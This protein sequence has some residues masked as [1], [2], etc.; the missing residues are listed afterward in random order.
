MRVGGVERD[1]EELDFLLREHVA[2]INACPEGEELIGPQRVKLKERVP[3]GVPLSDCSR[4]STRGFGFRY[5][6]QIWRLKLSTSAY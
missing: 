4:S 1:A 2:L 5:W 3:G 6:V